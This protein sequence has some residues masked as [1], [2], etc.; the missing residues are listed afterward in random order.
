[1]SAKLNLQDFLDDIASDVKKEV[2]WSFAIAD[3]IE[4]ILQKENIST[5]NLPDVWA[6]AKPKCPVGLAARI[7]SP[8]VPLQRF[9]LSSVKI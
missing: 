2:D 7:I 5:R 3:K 6:K 4:S 1:M 9:Q 8:C